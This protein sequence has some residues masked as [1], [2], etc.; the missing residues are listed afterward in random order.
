MR[1]AASVMTM[2]ISIVAVKKTEKIGTSILPMSWPNPEIEELMLSSV[3][4]V[5]VRLFIL[6][7]V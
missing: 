2:M 3:V 6:K 5:A 7:I 1:N 4:P